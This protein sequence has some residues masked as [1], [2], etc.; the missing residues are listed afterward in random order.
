MVDLKSE[1]Q[2]LKQELD[3]TIT[4]SLSRGMYI[5]GPSVKELEKLLSEFLKVD[6]VVGCANGTDA[7]QI[8]LMAIDA[9]PG[10]EIIVPS[11]TYVATAEVIA[12][13]GLKPILVDVD[14]NSFNLDIESVL[15]AVTPRTKAI[16]PVHL[17][18]QGS[19]MSELMKLAAAG[20]YIIEDNAQSL[21]AQYRFGETDKTIHLGT[22]GHIG[23]TSFYPSKILGCYGDGGA[24][25]TNDAHLAKRIRMISNH[26]QSKKY[27]HEII[28]CN[29]RLDDIQAAILSIKMQYV[30]ERIIQRQRVARL[31]DE[32]LNNIEGVLI[33]KRD[34]FSDHV[35]H[36][37][38]L[39][40]TNNQR[41]GLQNH[42][43]SMGVPS[44]IYYPLP[45]H[46]QA[47]F[48]SFVPQDLCLPNTEKLCNEVISLPICPFL[49][50]KDQIHVTNGIKKFFN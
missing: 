30:N 34:S 27:Y 28:G 31:Y 9:K 40:I 17:F 43:K 20:I 41:D 22:I 5:N 39:R 32:L 16:V 33:P 26:G 49:K 15:S 6:S 12:L 25:M 3:T 38:T 36:Q 14:M 46:K 37:Y 50:E 42:L 4:N 48:R 11:F 24:L 1:Y 23:T 13:L 47:A 29:S 21:G 10:D 44:M 35:F 8:A 45:L 19:N 7:L 2:A 18:G